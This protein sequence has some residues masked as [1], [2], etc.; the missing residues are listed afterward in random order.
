MIRCRLWALLLLAP[1]AC[2]LSGGEGVDETSSALQGINFVQAASSTPHWSFRS[3]ATTYGQAQIA[4]DTNIVPICWSDASSSV[5]SVTDTMH[6]AYAV[7]APVV[8]LA[9]TASCTMYYAANIKAAAANANVVTVKFSARV[10]NPDVRIAEYS[11]LSATP[12]DV[13]AGATG[14]GTSASSGTAVTTAPGDLIVGA[15]YDQ[16]STTGAGPGFTSRIITARDSDILEDEIAG[17]P[18]AYAA[19]APTSGGWWVMQMAAFKAAKVADAGAG[20]GG[21][22]SSEAGTD[23]S[24]EA[25]TDAS[26][27]GGTDASSGG[28]TDASSQTGMDAS[29]EGGM[30]SG[31]GMGGADAGPETGST[32]PDAGKGSPPPPDAGSPTPDAGVGS[33]PPPDA[34]GAPS[35]LVQ[36]V[37]GSN[38]RNNSMTSPYCYTMQLPAGATA[39]NAIVVGVTWKGNAT[40]KVSDDH[41]DSYTNSEA[42]FDSADNQSVGIASSFGV[43]AGA[44]ALSVC[45]S[46]DPGGWVEPMAT[47]FAGVV[48]VD[49]AG[50]GGNGTGTSAAAGA[51]TPHGSDLLYQVVYTPGG[52]P[53]RFSAAGGAT[54]LSA[55]TLDG[56]AGQFGPAVAGAPSLSLGSSVHW[57]T[58]ALLLRTGSAGGVPSGMRILHLE[59]I[60]LPVSPGAVAGGAGYPSPTPIEFPSG[61]NLLVAAIGGGCGCSNVA[62]VSGITDSASNAWTQAK[63]QGDGDAMS[64]IFYA[65]NAKSASSLMLSVAWDSN[66]TDD[67]TAMLYD[68]T[69]AASS[70]FDVAAGA[71]GAANSPG[72]FTVPFTITPSEPGELVFLATPWDF[73]TAGGLIGGLIDTNI[74]SGESESG[75]FPVDENNGWGHAVST[76][77][78]PMSFTWVPLYSGI[79]FGISASVAAAFKP[80]P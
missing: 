67:S 18:G 50:T 2:A 45:F 29:N 48:G 19:T 80:A 12:L 22:G 3:V 73:D 76:S 66:N 52:S 46:A 30:T 25:G 32:T 1:C 31:G 35:T 51:L 34:G 28:G 15:D 9:G 64:Q 55:D 43:A 72:N 61:G 70:P 23:A 8:R 65:G 7:A 79:E 69:G 74:T 21:T 10:R 58:A 60:N 54:L 24:S 6:N 75:P 42:F 56:W 47:E 13:S 16:G 77:T 62:F 38:L 33:P 37:S 68:V 71:G 14:N 39:G 5:V 11:G 49:G 44:R 63:K 17:A 27:K 26:S 78:S 36:H 40:L 20:G 4:G 53:S 59:H 57:T 41:G